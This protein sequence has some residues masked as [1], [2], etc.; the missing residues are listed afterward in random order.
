MVAEFQVYMISLHC[1]LKIHSFQSESKNVIV[2]WFLHHMHHEVTIAEII[3]RLFS[4]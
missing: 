2:S 4:H 3:K 1:I